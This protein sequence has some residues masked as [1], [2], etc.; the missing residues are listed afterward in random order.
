MRRLVKARR[1][2]A[3]DWSRV[4]VNGAIAA[5]MPRNAI[6]LCAKLALRQRGRRIEVWFGSRDLAGLLGRDRRNV[7]RDLRR[8]VR[9]GLLEVFRGGGRVLG[10]K[11]GKANI[12]VLGAILTASKMTPL[13]TASKM[14]PLTASKMTPYPMAPE[15]VNGVKNDAPSLRDTSYPSGVQGG[16]TAALTGGSPSNPP[17]SNLAARVKELAQ[18]FSYDGGV[19]AR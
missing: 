17:A 18:K 2:P 11:R 3:V 13:I 9:A 19:D 4:L 5:K 8:L 16:R 15:L 6:E 1:E 14:T 12:Y 10:S 7:Q